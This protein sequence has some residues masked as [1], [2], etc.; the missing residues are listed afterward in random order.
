MGPIAV[1]ALENATTP[2][3]GTLRLH[4][5]KCLKKTVVLR[6]R[7]NHFVFRTKKSLRHPRQNKKGF[8]ND[9]MR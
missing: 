3:F 5:C 4:L 6:Y 7:H 8:V 2:I 1:L 9:V